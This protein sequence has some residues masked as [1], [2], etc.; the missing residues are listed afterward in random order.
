MSAAGPIVAVAGNINGDVT[1][2]VDRMPLIGETM[3]ARELMVGPGGKASNESVALTRLG[4]TPRLIGNVG[5]DA[6]GDMVLGWLRE[7][8]VD[9][10]HVA[11]CA[12]VATGMATVIVDRGAENAI[13]T[14]LGANL[15]MQPD[16]LPSLEGCGALLM[17][18]GLPLEV[19]VAAAERARALG[20]PVF[21]DTTPLRTNGI[22]PELA[23]ADVLSCNAIEAELLTGVA[24]DEDAVD[25]CCRA[26]HALG[27]ARVVLKLGARGAA[28]FEG[29]R[30]ER[31]AA[32]RVE[33]VD[34]TGAGDAFMAGLTFRLLDG[35]PLAEAARFACA[36]GAAATLGP[37]A[38]GGWTSLDDVTRLLE[39]DP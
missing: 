20:I 26:L 25:D 33:A 32:P 30:V 28:V 1:Y 27:G 29:E 22:P 21:V 37:G 8:G 9:T 6:I 19:L 14:H 23:A 34:P 17:T 11:R 10:A 2:A 15:S 16:D 31:V 4:V 7:A 12:G 36:V 18:L 38:Q 39:I 13:V 24:P 35:D 5:Q 3:L